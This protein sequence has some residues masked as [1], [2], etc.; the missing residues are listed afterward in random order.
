MN[1]TVCMLNNYMVNGHINLQMWAM[2]QHSLTD[3]AV[4]SQVLI[5]LQETSTAPWA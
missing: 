4:T 1:C 2:G 3:K 5:I